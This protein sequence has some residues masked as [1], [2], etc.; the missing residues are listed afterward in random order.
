MKPCF[1][2]SIYKRR[3]EDNSKYIEYFLGLYDS[4]IY[5]NIQHHFQ[6]A[7]EKWETQVLEFYG[8][9]PYWAGAI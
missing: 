9:S 6:S 1:K 8:C 3:F 7:D 2:R 4:D 5:L